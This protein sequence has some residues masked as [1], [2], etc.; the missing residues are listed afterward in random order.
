V[1]GCSESVAPED[2]DIV[3]TWALTAL[4]GASGN[5]NSQWTFAQDGTYQWAFF[6][7]VLG[8]DL[9]GGGTYTLSDDVLSVSG[10]VAGTVISTLSDKRLTLTL[11]TNSFSFLDEEGDRWTYGRQ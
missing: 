9:D 2:F 4:E 8:F 11:E 5:Y 3:D 1:L 10:I 7:D 6:S